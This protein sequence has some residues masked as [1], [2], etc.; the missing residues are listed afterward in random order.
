MNH[1]QNRKIAQVTVPSVSMSGNQDGKA[2]FRSGTQRNYSRRLRIIY[3]KRS[4]KRYDVPE[5][6]TGKSEKNGARQNGS[7][8]QN[9]REQ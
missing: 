2:F 9:G 1:T 5:Q 6:K 3:S 8:Q 7:K 4:K